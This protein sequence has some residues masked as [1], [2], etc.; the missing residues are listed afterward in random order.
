MKT[1]SK[2]KILSYYEDFRRFECVIGQDLPVF[3]YVAPS[4]LHSP[5]TDFAY[6]RPLA[7]EC[8]D[9]AE[10]GEVRAVA[11]LKKHEISGRRFLIKLIAC[12]PEWRTYVNDI[13][14]TVNGQVI[15]R[16]EREFFENVN[17]G[18]PALYFPVPHNLLVSGEN[19]I[20]VSTDNSSGA[21]L[22][23][24]LVGLVSL[25]KPEKYSQVS[26]VESVRAGSEYT[27][28]FECGRENVEVKN[29][30]NCRVIEIVNCDH[31]DELTLIKFVS[32]SEGV[33]SCEVW[34]ESGEGVKALM[35][36]VCPASEDFFL[37]GTDSDD[38]RHDDSEETDRIIDVFAMSGMGNF[39]QLRPMPR[40]NN[41]D[42]LSLQKWTQRLLYLKAFGVRFGLSGGGDA[43]GGDDSGEFVANV[44][45]NN[46]LGSHIHEPYL[47]F[48]KNL[49]MFKIN[50][51]GKDH[52]AAE[53]LPASESFGQSKAIYMKLL[54]QTKNKYA[55]KSGLSSVGS[56]SLLCVYEASAGFDRVTIE[57][58]SNINILTGAVR[59]TGCRMWG[60]HVPTDW[61]FGSPT[62]EVKSRKFLLAM[63]YLYLNGA[64]YVYA[65]NSLFK[66]NAFDRTDWD[67]KFCITNRKYLR[68]FYDYTVRNPR[69]GTLRTNLAVVY[70]NNEFFM[71]HHDDRMA[72]LTDTVVWDKTLWGKWGNST[73]HKCWRAIDAWLPL[74][75]H[76][77]VFEGRVNKRLFSGSPYGSV[78]VVAHS[79]NFTPYK[80][81]AFLGWNTWED[82]QLQTLTDFVKNGGTLFISHC[83]FNKTDRCDAPMEYADSE[84]ISSLIG[85]RPV[86]EF[87][88]K[89]DVTFESGVKIE[90]D[91]AIK[92]CECQEAGAK[93][94][95]RDES[96]K[97]VFYRYRLGCGVVYFAAFSRYFEN[98]WAI[99]ATK[100]VLEQMAEECAQV[101]CD[102]PNISV[103]ERVCSDGSLVINTLNMNCAD[104]EKQKQ[105]YTIS[106]RTNSGTKVIKGE[107][108]PCLIGCHVI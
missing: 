48:N 83:H 18:W 60:A 53:L 98:E 25:A 57:P 63:Q 77:N 35:P 7:R 54:E 1:S 81:V 71:W 16:N 9:V 33:A 92:A 46:Y 87:V 15:H 62:D 8:V 88:P 72:E 36:V 86:G 82:S 105:S 64:D 93:A 103:T 68:D 23:V 107:L 41:V 37:A 32:D 30:S 76:Q 104:D 74:A 20:V 11:S 26:F 61:Y 19:E 73:H 91:S 2:E 80:A 89:G 13:S 39:F 3:S 10:A 102:N 69:L 27:I 96:G 108:A 21:G 66:T 12:I 95:A 34:F 6:G 45:G 52:T 58:V 28:A 40:R 5:I 22:Y 79:G 70:G 59:A 101:H 78:D 75:D 90:I 97:P 31:K 67:D 94:I 4:S 51:D 50:I 47:F 29:T 44:T 56:A 24:S 85:V 99:E 43:F 17:L 14:I 65:E 106:V 42:F 84:L 49:T 55:T 38:H 100:Q